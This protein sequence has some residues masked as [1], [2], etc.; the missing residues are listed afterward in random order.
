MIAKIIEKILCWIYPSYFEVTFDYPNLDRHIEIYP[1]YND[2]KTR[3]DEHLGKSPKF[4]AWYIDKYI[5]AR[6]HFLIKVARWHKG[7]YIEKTK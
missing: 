5:N 4:S 2:A 6:P 1:T 7:S 3:V